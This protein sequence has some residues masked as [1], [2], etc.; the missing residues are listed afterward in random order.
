MNKKIVFIL[1]VLGLLVISYSCKNESDSENNENRKS[2][3]GKV[4][5]GYV[6]SG[7][8]FSAISGVNIREKFTGATALTDSAGYFEIEF[9]E[10]DCGAYEL[11]FSRTGFEEEKVK[12]PDNGLSRQR[13]D[14]FMIPEL[15]GK[16]YYVSPSGSDKNNGSKSSPWKTPG[17]AS[18]QIHAGD[19][20]IIEKGTYVVKEFDYDILKPRRGDSEN[21]IVIKGEDGAV[22]KGANNILAVIDLS[23]SSHIKLEN[24]EITNDQK[25][26]VRDGIEIFGGL[27]ESV[28]LK[29]LHIHHIDEFGINVRDV[30][31]FVLEYS[32]IEYCG[33]GAFGGPRGEYGGI[34]NLKILF[35]YLSYSGHYYQGGDGSSRPYDRPDGFGIEPSAGPVEI[36]DSVFEHN[37]GDG[38]DS[39]ASDTYVHNCIIA[40]NSCDGVKLWRGKSKIE[41]TLIYGTGDGIG[42]DSPWAGIVID[43]D[44]EGDSFEI[45][46]TTLHDNV[47]RRAYPMYVQYDNGA[48]IKVKIINSIFSGGFG[49]LWFRDS[50]SLTMK[51]NLI[52]IPSRNDQIYANGRLYSADDINSG[53]LGEGNIYADPQFIKPAWGKR[54]DYHLKASS[55]AI[56]S[57]TKGEAPSDDLEHTKRPQ[58]E[59][60]DMGAY[61]KTKN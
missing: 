13:A 21:W 26:L 41:N 4:I 43:S 54:G 35:S 15:K 7:N 59:N 49:H 40:N 14:V 18:K 42:G 1:I 5:F 23:S 6:L 8:D 46:N 25:S 38:I 60:P 48:K 44:R 58:G 10:V 20:L 22:L 31:H 61:E 56:D 28:I 30:N 55:K 53:V 47:Q 2:S 45:I 24:I 34:R 3:S 16:V 17:F 19:K 57:G 51:Y 39:K 36:Y 12:I 11:N 37:Y 52:Y 29:N 50:V 33:F 9:E 27:V 32:K